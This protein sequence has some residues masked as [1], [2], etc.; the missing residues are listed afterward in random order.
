MQTIQLIEEN[1]GNP[2]IIYPYWQENQHFLDEV[3]LQYLTNW[4]QSFIKTAD[5]ETQQYLAAILIH[6][7]NLITTISFRK[8]TH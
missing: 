8:K 3:L 2:R 5:S 7:G 6:L 4:Y 1:N